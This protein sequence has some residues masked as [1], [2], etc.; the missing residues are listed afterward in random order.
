MPLPASLTRTFYVMAHF[1]QQTFILHALHALMR[2]IHCLHCLH[3]STFDTACSSL[4][5][6]LL[7]NGGKST[8]APCLLFTDAHLHED[9]I[10]NPKA[11]P[12]V[13]PSSSLNSLA[14][15]FRCSLSTEPVMGPMGPTPGLRT[16]ARVTPLAMH[17]KRTLASFAKFDRLE[18]RLRLKLRFPSR[19]GTEHSVSHCNGLH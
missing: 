2:S 14:Y 13:K 17:R 3:R 8:Y 7:L 16:P 6:A 10:S 4:T 1:F 9:E 5:P 18:A 12:I 19:M 15:Y 11:L